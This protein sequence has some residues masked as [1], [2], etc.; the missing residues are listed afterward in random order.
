MNLVQNNFKQNYCLSLENIRR[1]QN[2]R[3]SWRYIE[4]VQGVIRWRE[5]KDKRKCYQVH[6]QSKQNQWPQGE[7]VR[8]CKNLLA[9]NFYF[10]PRNMHLAT[11]S[12]CSSI[13]S[14]V[15]SASS[16]FMSFCPGNSS[17][18]AG[19]WWWSKM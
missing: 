1:G 2:V 11:C 16:C 14:I 3:H 18:L 5:T 7:I 9:F 17:T 12:V 4:V 6:C 8:I 15:S 19:L 13:L 10:C